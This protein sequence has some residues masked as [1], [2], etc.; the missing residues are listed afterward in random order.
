MAVVRAKAVSSV[1]PSSTLTNLSLLRSNRSVKNRRQSSKRARRYN[2]GVPTF[3][4]LES[5]SMLAGVFC[6][7]PDAPF[8]YQP[9][10]DPVVGAVV[11]AFVSQDP[12][13]PND[14]YDILT[15]WK[16]AADELHEVGATEVSFAV[17]RQVNQG[18][19]S[20][21]PSI[22]TVAQAVE[23]AVEKDLSV[24]ILPLFETDQGWRGDYDPSGEERDVFQSQYMQWISDLAE[25]DGI[26]RF[27]IGSELNA[28]VANADNAEFF[29]DLLLAAEESFTVAENSDAR[30][31][32]A[33]NHD[34]FHDPGHKVLFGQR[35]MDFIGISAY[36]WLTSSGDAQSVAGTGEFSDEVFES[37][38]EN[39]TNFLDEVEL[40]ASEF[41]LP[42]VLQEVGAVQQNYASVAPFAVNPGDFVAYDAVERYAYDPYEQEAIFKSV[43][44]ALDGRGDTFESVTFWTWEHQASRGRRTTDVLGVQDGFESFAIYPTDGGGGEFL[45]E[46]LASAPS[47]TPSVDAYSETDDGEIS[48]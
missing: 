27:N 45:T 18:A 12:E 33:A 15:G 3:E 42:V 7:T 36:K 34:A 40:A 25:I 22:S 48:N 46:Y 1:E 2:S 47:H 5:R 19:L 20:G 24:T 6:M 31:G 30:I 13:D 37:F 39:W 32:Y 17:F 35:E 4:R 11:T 29:S 16:A 38:E 43:I 44:S 9:T 23:Y 28:M 14:S 21:G 10:I 8:S 26:D 41:D